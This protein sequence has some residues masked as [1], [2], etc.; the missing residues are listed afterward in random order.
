MGGVSTMR[1][2]PAG[3]EWKGSSVNRQFN[4]HVHARGRFMPLSF[5]EIDRQNRGLRWVRA[6]HEPA[7]LHELCT[8]EF[9][10][11]RGPGGLPWQDDASLVV[12]KTER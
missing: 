10:E 7:L 1:L 8:G 5:A 6:G 9:A 11:L 4:R 12:S 3:V 2:R